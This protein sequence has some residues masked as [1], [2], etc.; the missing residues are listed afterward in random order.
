MPDT[1]GKIFT[2]TSEGDLLHQAEILTLRQISGNLEGMN[3]ELQ[4]SRESMTELKIDVAVIK[5]RQLQNTKMEEKVAAL[6]ADIAL[7]KARNTRQDGAFSFV[8]MLKDFGPWVV[9]FG[10]MVY[11]LLQH[12]V[13]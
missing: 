13:K 3:R 1:A 10:M 12:P 2:P 6:E 7:L 11:G 9:A 5:E 4:A 8:T